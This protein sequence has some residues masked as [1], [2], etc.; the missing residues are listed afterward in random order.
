MPNGA[1][2]AHTLI[3][4]TCDMQSLLAELQ[5]RR[6][7]IRSKW[8][9]L[10]RTEPVTSP[11]ADPDSLVHL[12][13]STMEEILAALPAGF[14]PTEA[15][16]SHQPVPCSC[17]RNPLLAFFAAG[18]QAMREGLVLSQAALAPLDPSLRDASLITLNRVIDE[19]AL[20]EIEAFCGLC[21][22]RNGH[23]ARRSSA[24]LVV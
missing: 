19:I 4:H 1:Q 12:I 10:L 11:L 3:W 7:A 20:R 22:F 14:L 13:D 15:S 21:Q 5:R 16:T 8:E 6:A 24:L 2:R 23:E 18:R 9:A 17:G